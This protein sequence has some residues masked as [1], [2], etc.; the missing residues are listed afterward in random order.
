M[1]SVFPPQN[2]PE[3]T[4]VRSS[5]S[6]PPLRSLR[7]AVALPSNPNC[8]SVRLVCWPCLLARTHFC[9]LSFT[10]PPHPARPALPCLVRVLPPQSFPFPALFASPLSASLLGPSPASCCRQPTIRANRRRPLA[11]PLHF[12]R[13]SSRELH[14][15]V[16]FP[17]PIH[18]AAATTAATTLCT[19][20]GKKKTCLRTNPPRK[21]RS[22]MQCS[23]PF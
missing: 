23:R 15:Y 4:V 3:F 11:Q 8:Q 2:L 14:W 17:P 19:S 12:S 16:L 10:R 9:T 22:A 18:P 13:W 1:A 7:S 5:E 20:P 6:R 21:L